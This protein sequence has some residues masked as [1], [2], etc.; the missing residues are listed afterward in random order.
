VPNSAGPAGTP[1][2]RSAT[3]Q[4]AQGTTPARPASIG[5][6]QAVE[7]TR[8]SPASTG[9]TSTPPVP[10]STAMSQALDA[11]TT[12]PTPLSLPSGAPPAPTDTPQVIAVYVSGAV[13]KPGV[14]TLAL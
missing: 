2:P 8:E 1:E 4:Q 3:K 13:H 9:S 7:A 14:Y 6:T 11:A 5:I 10:A 12:P